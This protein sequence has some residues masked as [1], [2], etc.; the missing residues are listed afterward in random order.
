GVYAVIGL[1]IIFEEP[2]AAFPIETWSGVLMVAR[3][4]PDRTSAMAW[5]HC[6]IRLS[7]FLES[8]TAAV[9]SIAEK[10]AVKT[11]LTRSRRLAVAVLLVRK[12]LDAVCRH[13][14]H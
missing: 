2:V 14:P 6:D 13:G 5:S 7:F 1:P 8:S 9:A 4:L 10:L 11:S 12:I 3:S